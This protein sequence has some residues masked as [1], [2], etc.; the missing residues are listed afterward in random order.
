MTPHALT[1]CNWDLYDLFSKLNT[2][3]NHYKVV[4]VS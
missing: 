1:E 3:S 2:A 4:L